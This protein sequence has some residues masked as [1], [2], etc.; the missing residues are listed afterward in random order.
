MISFN[1]IVSI[2]MPTFNGETT[3]LKSI[4]SILNQ[5]YSNIELII[6]NDCSND[7]TLELITLIKDNRI[8]IINN[9]YNL[10]IAKSLNIGI[11][12][13]SGD[14]IARID[15]DDIAYLNRI[16]KQVKI[17]YNSG[18]DVLGGQIQTFGKLINPKYAYPESNK[19]ICYYSLLGNPIAHP[20]VLAT[21]SFFKKNLYNSD[22]KY[23]GFEDYE[24]WT[25]SISNNYTFFNMPNTI[26]SYRM[27]N[28]QLSANQ[29]SNFKKRYFEF[30][31]NL[32]SSLS[33]NLDPEYI[34][35]YKKIL[36]DKDKNSINKIF[37]FYKKNNLNF[38]SKILN[39]I[40]LILNDECN[41]KSSL[42]EKI[43]LYV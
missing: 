37:D 11:H 24:L 19:Q 6:V 28:S 36:I 26:L 39:Q 23:L 7:N 38:N 20:T 31:N 17:I 12:A 33:T 43:K 14:Y 9:D 10:G 41:I 1:P 2:I 16:K 3:I 25:R 18:V 8:K 34:N 13:S 40:K 42:T 32:L 21:A 15:S 27:S 35:I 29:K 30:K 22:I 4:K 5:T